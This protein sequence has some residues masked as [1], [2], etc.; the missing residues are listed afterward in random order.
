MTVFLPLDIYTKDLGIIPLAKPRKWEVQFKYWL[1]WTIVGHAAWQD[2]GWLALWP[3]HFSRH[4][5]GPY[6]PDVYDHDTGRMIPYVSASRWTGRRS[7]I[8]GISIFNR[9]YI[10]LYARRS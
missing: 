6:D 5:P 4:T 1:S 10:N 3:V 7:E 9:W 2:L 8:C